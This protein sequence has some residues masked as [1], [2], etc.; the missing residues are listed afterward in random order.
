[1]A[2]REK[3]VL[4]HKEP[5]LTRPLATTGRVGATAATGADAEP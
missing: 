2:A 5:A 4:T 1:M 3:A